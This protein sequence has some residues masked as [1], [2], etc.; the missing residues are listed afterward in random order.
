MPFKRPVLPI[1]LLYILAAA[2][3]FTAALHNQSPAHAGTETIRVQ[4]AMFGLYGSQQWMCFGLKGWHL[5]EDGISA[6]IFQDEGTGPGNPPDY[7][8]FCSGTVGA[9]W[10]DVKGRSTSP[11]WGSYSMWAQLYGSSKYGCP[12]TVADI[13]WWNPGVAAWVKIGAEVYW[14]TS[15]SGYVPNSPS[16]VSKEI[17]IGDGVWVDA[18][19]RLGTT[20]VDNTCAWTAHHTHQTFREKASNITITPNTGTLV[21]DADGREYRQ[22]LGSRHVHEWTGW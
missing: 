5:S 4:G 15:G 1:A 12:G 21:T 6:D 3:G 18:W 19:Q 7:A 20:I 2:I 17:I 9:V 8:D 11:Y 10:F 16:Y 13:F 14:H 22:D